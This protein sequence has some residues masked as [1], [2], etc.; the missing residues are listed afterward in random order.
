MKQSASR[1]KQNQN[2]LKLQSMKV[3]LN[4]S[5]VV[6]QINVSCFRGLFF[7]YLNENQIKHDKTCQKQCAYSV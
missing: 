4:I 3:D 6:S 2:T 1:L 5:N 7:R